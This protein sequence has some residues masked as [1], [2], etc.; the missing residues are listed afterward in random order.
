MSRMMFVMQ[1][2]MA[3]TGWYQ[4]A[5]ADGQITAPEVADLLNTVAAATGHGDAVVAHVKST[6]VA[7]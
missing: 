4:R 2:M 3:V 1:V 6:Q 7:T 5:A